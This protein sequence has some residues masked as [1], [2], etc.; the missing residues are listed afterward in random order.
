MYM[1]FESFPRYF[2]VLK[3]YG[4]VKLKGGFFS[5]ATVTFQHIVL[6]EVRYFSGVHV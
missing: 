3:K 2:N 6:S 4:Y 5:K 1:F